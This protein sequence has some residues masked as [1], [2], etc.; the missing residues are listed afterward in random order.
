MSNLAKKERPSS[1]E[2]W[3]SNLATNNPDL[4]KAVTF[5][6]GLYETAGIIKPKECKFDLDDAQ[7]VAFYVEDCLELGVDH[8]N[9]VDHH[10]EVRRSLKWWPTAAEFATAFSRFRASTEV[11]PAQCVGY[12]V[13]EGTDQLILCDR[14]KHPNALTE[15]EAIAR[16]PDYMKA[17]KVKALP[18]PTKSQP[19]MRR[20]SDTSDI[21]ITE[22]DIQRHAKKVAQMMV[23]SDQEKENHG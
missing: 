1:I 15:S 14:R 16:L 9:L 17:P 7:K 19:G 12:I 13:P 8:L 3:K 11:V 4:W 2:A 18:A 21:I 20:I 10:A 5:V 23:A 22:A 6:L